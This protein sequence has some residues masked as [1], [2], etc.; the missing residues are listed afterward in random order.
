MSS[1]DDF[2]NDLE[3]PAPSSKAPPSTSAPSL[4]ASAAPASSSSSSSAGALANENAILKKNIS[5]LF[6]TA[7]AELRRKDAE[8]LR[9]QDIINRLAQQGPP[10]PQQQLLHPQQRYQQPK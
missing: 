9:L 7:K 5:I 3:D 2:Y 1:Y 8:I 10:P 6:R 4:S